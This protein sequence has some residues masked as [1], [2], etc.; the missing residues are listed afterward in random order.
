[1]SSISWDRRVKNQPGPHTTSHSVF[2][3]IILYGIKAAAGGG[4]THA[5][6]LSPAVQ[7]RP[8]DRNHDTARGPT[9]RA[10]SRP[11]RTG[12][13][14]V[15]SMRCHRPTQLFLY[16]GGVG[17]GA[18]REDGAGPQ[19]PEA[20][21]AVRRS[22]PGCAASSRPT[23]RQRRCCEND[24]WIPNWLLPLPSSSPSVV[25][26]RRVEKLWTRS[27]SP[28]RRWLRDQARQS[29]AYLSKTGSFLKH[30][31]KPPTN[32]GP[33][34]PAVKSGSVVEALLDTPQRP[35]AEP[36]VKISEILIPSPMSMPC[37][38]LWPDP[39]LSVIKQR[40][41]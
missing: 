12:L 5:Q 38:Q 6:N 20:T 31:G 35:E 27:S 4:T 36:T 32:D 13:A 16:L 17:R 9:G 26:G 3:R 11:G 22:R 7:P 25:V 2:C 39:L 15:T 8:F 40:Q 29:G 30:S 41:R 19:S 23:G 28:D 14:P 24:P 10:R 34:L 33:A 1:M 18:G 37:L 21:K